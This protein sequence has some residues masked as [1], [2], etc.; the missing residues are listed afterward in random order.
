VGEIAVQDCELPFYRGRTEENV[1]NF[2]KFI[3]ENLLTLI[4]LTWRIG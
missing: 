3:G 1:E 2:C 4:L